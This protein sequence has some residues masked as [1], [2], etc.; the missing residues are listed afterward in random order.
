MLVVRRL[1]VGPQTQ[2]NLGEPQG[3][4]QPHF[5]LMVDDLERQGPVKR[6]PHPADRRAKPVELTASGS[7]AAARAAAIIDEPPCRIEWRAGRRPSGGA[8]GSRT[9]RMEM[10]THCRAE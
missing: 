7:G 6:Q 10:R 5:T 4:S 1:A 9:C 3:T 8:A 2:G